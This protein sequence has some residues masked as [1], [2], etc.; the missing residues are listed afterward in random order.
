MY[1]L[2]ILPVSPSAPGSLYIA[3][4]TLSRS[5][6]DHQFDRLQFDRALF[7]NNDIG[8][9]IY[10]LERTM[11]SPDSKALPSVTCY[12]DGMPDGLIHT[13]INQVSE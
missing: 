3:G 13:T 10:D 5:T 7:S 8:T 1:M 2:R 4:K 6:S 12:R 11:V 9:L